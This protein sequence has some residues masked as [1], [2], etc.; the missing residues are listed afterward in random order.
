LNISA[1][2]PDQL[3]LTLI[4][5]SVYHN[6]TKEWYNKEDVELRALHQNKTIMVNLQPIIGE[7]F[8]IITQIIKKL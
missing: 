8:L 1:P 3:P 2:P 4:Y 6:Q 5:I 7:L